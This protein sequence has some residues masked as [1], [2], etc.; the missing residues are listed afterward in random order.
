MSEYCYEGSVE[1]ELTVRVP[2]SIQGYSPWPD[3]LAWTEEPP[4][5]VVK[6]ARLDALQSLEKTLKKA[7]HVTI[8]D[9]NDIYPVDSGDLESFTIL[10]D[11][12]KMDEGRI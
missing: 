4:E 12:E 5:D 8:Q 11:T 1:V 6:A 10:Y 2:I 7:Q 9:G 3:D